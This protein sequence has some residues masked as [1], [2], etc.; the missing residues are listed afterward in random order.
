MLEYHTITTV[1][2]RLVYS[3]KFYYLYHFYFT[4]YKDDVHN[5]RALFSTPT[6]VKYTQATATRIATT[7]DDSDLQHQI[8]TTIRHNVT[9]TALTTIIPNDDNNTGAKNNTTRGHGATG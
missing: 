6:A 8:V 2:R 4:V 3:N 7:V 1:P 9:T 5:Q